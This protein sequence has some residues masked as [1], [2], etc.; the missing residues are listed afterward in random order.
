P[1]RGECGP[2]GVALARRGLGPVVPGMGDLAGAGYDRLLAA[3]GT[4]ERHLTGEITGPAVNGSCESR[5]TRGATAGCGPAA[6]PPPGGSP[7]GFSGRSAS[8]THASTWAGVGSSG[9]SGT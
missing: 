7:H 3:D 6:T 8:S 5:R 1:S 4:P 2:D 9:R